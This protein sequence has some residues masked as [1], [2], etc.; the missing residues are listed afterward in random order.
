MRNKLK[1]KN[2]NI[3]NEKSVKSASDT[4]SITVLRNRDSGEISHSISD[5]V[6]LNNDNTDYDK[7][8]NE[9]NLYNN[10]DSAVYWYNY[11]IKNDTY[12]II[13]C[14]T[15]HNMFALTPA[16]DPNCPRS[17]QQAIR[18]PC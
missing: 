4:Q 3:E 15:R 7:N 16:R 1:N 10:D 6:I 14:E 17:Y 9:K 12:P 11:H 13:M 18:I 5:G 2:K 8:T